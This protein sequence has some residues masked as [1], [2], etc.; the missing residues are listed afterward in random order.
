VAGTEYRGQFEER[1]ENVIDEVL[2]NPEAQIPFIQ[3][4]S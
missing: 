4:Y 2:E 3:R 1:L